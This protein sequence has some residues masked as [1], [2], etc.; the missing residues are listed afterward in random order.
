MFLP[1]NLTPG[2]LWA[3]PVSMGQLV[4]GL[5]LDRPPWV[6]SLGGP[7][8]W[9]PSLSVTGRACPALL[10]LILRAPEILSFMQIEA[11]V[12]KPP[13]ISS[14]SLNTS[15][16][17]NTEGLVPDNHNEASHTNFLF[18]VLFT[19]YCSLF[20]VKWHYV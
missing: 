19:L 3:E 2:G 11:Y 16:P 18:C 1:Q 5:D 14:F 20:N 13:A 10:I 8:A 7:A 17:G 15:R 9:D 4:P 12:M 6:A